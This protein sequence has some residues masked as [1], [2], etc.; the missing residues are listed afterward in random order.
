MTARQQATASQR[1][2]AGSSSDSAD[3]FPAAGRQCSDSDEDVDVCS[4]RVLP[5]AA[6]PRLTRAAAAA[7]AARSAAASILEA[8]SAAATQAAT[9][10]ATI[11]SILARGISP[12]AADLE[13]PTAV[14]ALMDEGALA[15]PALAS[16]EPIASDALNSGGFCNVAN[17]CRAEAATLQIPS[18]S[19]RQPRPSDCESDGTAHPRQ[20]QESSPQAA[21]LPADVAAQQASNSCAYEQS[22]VSAA[23][24]PPQH[25]P[26]RSN[27]S[28]RTP[29]DA[30][31]TATTQSA[32]EMEVV[33]PPPGGWP[34]RPSAAK[35]VPASAQVVVC[36]AAAGK[37]PSGVNPA[38]GEAGHISRKPCQRDDSAAAQPADDE[39]TISV[40][41]GS[42]LEAGP[43]A[44]SQLKVRP[45]QLPQP[46]C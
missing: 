2:G 13:A 22:D 31:T 37:L 35:V 36:V 7:A 26:S 20:V 43:S 40:D 28:H 30:A 19:E 41:V 16:T 42:C 6:P 9:A 17:S 11:P 32:D 4:P 23:A 33:S 18:S 34:V 46:G 25:Q 45:S 44:T 10:A 3:A 1:W 29:F 14:T 39:E 27:S 5:P 38:G 8:N 24:K 12:A 15:S 21:S